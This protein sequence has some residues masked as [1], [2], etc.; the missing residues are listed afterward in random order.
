LLWQIY[1]P[2]KTLLDPENAEVLGYEAV[3]LGDAEVEK[4]ADISTLK[5]VKALRKLTKGIDLFKRPVSL[6]EAMCPA[7][8]TARLQHA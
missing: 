3:Y 6:P 7:P 8:Q 2:G 4:F 1:R 5:I